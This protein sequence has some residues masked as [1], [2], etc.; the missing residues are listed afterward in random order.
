LK[1]PGKQYKHDWAYVVY[2]SF[3][4]WWAAWFRM[5][6]KWKNGES[7]IYKPHF[8]LTQVNANM[9]QIQDEHEKLQW[10]CECLCRLKFVIYQ[11]KSLLLL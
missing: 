2:P 3:H 10:I 4:E 11:Q 5:I 8:S 1:I 7:R 9:L 6:E